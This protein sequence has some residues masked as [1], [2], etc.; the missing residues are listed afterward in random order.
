VLRS[1]ATAA[2][3]ALPDESSNG[4]PMSPDGHDTTSLLARADSLEADGNLV[5]AVDALTEANRAH[6]DPHIE[7][8]LVQLRHQAYWDLERSAGPSTWPVVPPGK[9]LVANGSPIVSAEELTPELLSTGILRHGCVHVRRLVPEH[10]V[11]LLVDGIDRAIAGADAHSSH[12][13][14]NETDPWFA[15]L[16]PRPEYSV[17]VKRKWVRDSGGVWTADSPR[18]LA[19][20]VDT[21]DSVGLGRAINAYFGERPVLSVNKCTLRRVGLDPTNANWHQD[22]AFLGDG[23]RSVNVWLALSHCG[24]DAPGLDIVPKRLDRVVETGTEGAIFHW[25][26]GQGV[27]DKVSAE[28]PVRRP[29]FEPGDVLLFDDLFLHRTAVDPSMTRHR[30]AI[31]TWFFAPSAYPMGQIPLVF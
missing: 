29:V 17:G 28:S 23:I 30:Y 18:V 11:E 10:R 21:I 16:K 6:R 26:V 2:K 14:T 19:D 7:R 1:S 5:D 22:G 27:V 20:L 25:A 8:R 15:P 31:E 4:A 9:D 12:A 13:N 3:L 24:R